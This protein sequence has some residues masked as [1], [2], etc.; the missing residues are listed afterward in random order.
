MR[1]T[2]H[3]HWRWHRH[4]MRRG[5]C[6]CG[7]FMTQGCWTPDTLCNELALWRHQPPAA[8]STCQPPA[9]STAAYLSPSPQHG[10][11][12]YDSIRVLK[13]T[14]L[15]PLHPWPT[16][17][18]P[19]PKAC[20]HPRECG[21]QLPWT[22]ARAAVDPRRRGHPRSVPRLCECP[23]CARVV[24]VLYPRCASVVPVL[25]QSLGCTADY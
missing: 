13:L 14:P 18:P 20:E 5:G 7:F 22:S 4:K 9:A 19:P 6:S 10:V 1:G 24:P 16:H 21:G 15:L 3:W 23:C 17:D 11:T 2:V 12:S 25:C 8:T